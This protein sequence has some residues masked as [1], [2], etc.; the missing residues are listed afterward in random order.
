MYVLAELRKVFN[1]AESEAESNDRLI[2]EREK[3]AS[4]IYQGTN[5]NITIH[6]HYFEFTP[7]SLVKKVFLG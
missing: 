4:E 1:G 7:L 3:P 2:V 5:K 6:N